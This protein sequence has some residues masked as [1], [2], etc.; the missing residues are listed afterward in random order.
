MLAFFFFWLTIC[1]AFFLIELTGISM[2]FFLS[3]SVGALASAF[4][5]FFVYWI[6]WQILIFLGISGLALLLLRLA[7]NPK[8]FKNRVTNV[9]KLPGMHG[10]VT[11]SIAHGIVGQVNIQGQIWSAR[12]DGTQVL[13]E[14]TVI[15]VIR[16]QG[17]H[18]IVKK[19]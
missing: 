6:G 9:D 1:L 4:S 2:F 11:K 3:F 13:P 19:N 16:V 12:A 18:V 15:T 5:A 7:F 10:V 17:C 8:K 14:G